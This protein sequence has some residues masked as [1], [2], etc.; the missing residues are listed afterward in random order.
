LSGQNDCY[1]TFVD[2]ERVTRNDG[3]VLLLPPRIREF[4]PFRSVFVTA[5][6]IS[7]VSVNGEGVLEAALIAEFKD[8]LWV[9]LENGGGRW[10]Y[11][12]FSVS[13]AGIHPSIPKEGIEV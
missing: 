10:H 9:V 7:G 5:D 11:S 2:E 3:T 8:S 1:I 4:G 6:A 13:T 12:T